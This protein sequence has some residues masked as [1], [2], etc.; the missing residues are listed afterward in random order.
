MRKIIVGILCVVALSAAQAPGAAGADDGKN[1]PKELNVDFA[2]GWGG[3]FRPMEWTPIQIGVT[4]P[5]DK[6][7]DCIVELSA[8]QDDLNNL[9]ISRRE[10]F[11][12][13]ALGSS[14]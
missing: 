14:V 10:V 12:W 9:V 3:C 4:T 8:P 5:F 6:P 13:I 7:L 11:H 2:V 1:K